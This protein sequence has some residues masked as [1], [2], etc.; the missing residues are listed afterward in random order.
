[1]LLLPITLR[2]VLAARP[3][4]PVLQVVRRVRVR[5]WCRS[6]IW[7]APLG[8][9]VVAHGHSVRL[10]APKLVTPDRMSDKRGKND[11]VDASAIVAC[12]G[13]AIRP[14]KCV[15]AAVGARAAWPPPSCTSS[16]R[17]LPARGAC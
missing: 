9:S 3:V 5:D 17:R 14:I 10:L 16:S 15:A 4:L 6:V 1:V 7:Q 2:L 12:G 11:A 8:T 13:F